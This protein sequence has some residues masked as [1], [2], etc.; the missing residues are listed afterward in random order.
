[1]MVEQNLI[2]SILGIV[3]LYIVLQW[4][5]R[6]RMRR[7]TDTSIERELAEILNHDEYKVKGRFE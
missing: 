4:Y 6:R 2:Y 1:M 7:S 3:G 5:L